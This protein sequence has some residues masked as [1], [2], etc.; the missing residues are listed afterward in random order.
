MAGWPQCAQV[1][2]PGSFI[3]QW[4]RR[5]S[6]RDR[7]IRLLGTA[8]TGNSFRKSSYS[9]ADEVYSFSSPKAAQRGSAANGGQEQGPVFRSWPQRWHKPWHS[10]RQ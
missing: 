3:F 5:L 10:G 2:R 7:E 4:V 6:R 8:D 1:V 9:D